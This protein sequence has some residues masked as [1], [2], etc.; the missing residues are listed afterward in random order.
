[1]A[2]IT[3][4]F[5]SSIVLSAASVTALTNGTTGTPV[6]GVTIPFALTNPSSDGV[7]WQ[8]SFVDPSGSAA[9][10]NSS[11][12]I[13]LAAG[14]TSGPFSYVIQGSGSVVGFW[15]SQLLCEQFIGAYSA[16]ALSNLDNGSTGANAAGYLDAI[17]QATTFND[18]NLQLFGYPS[19]V[20]NP[21]F[22][23]TSFAFQMLS[24][25]ATILACGWLFIK[26]GSTEED[27]KTIAG[28]FSRM[29]KDAKKAVETVIRNRITDVPRTGYT[30]QP[31]IVLN[32]ATGAAFGTKNPLGSLSPNQIG[33]YP[34]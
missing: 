12:I 25:S 17:M 18:Y 31:T 3:F 11:I 5:T 9:Y 6:F 29:V 7:T 26:R 4:A 20:T 23:K 10:Y 33:A 27:I 22:P 16:D 15:T 13:T 21:Q 34:D 1:M 2:T 28:A 14:G 32:P 24:Q 8:G 30:N 19:S